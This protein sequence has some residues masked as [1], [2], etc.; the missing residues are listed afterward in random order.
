MDEQKPPYCESPTWF[1]VVLKDSSSLL[2]DFKIKPG[3]VMKVCRWWDHCYQT[4][5]TDYD[6]LIWRYIIE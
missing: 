1:E 5:I 2:K 6:I 3:E 4:L